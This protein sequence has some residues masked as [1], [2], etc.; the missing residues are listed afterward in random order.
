MEQR[1][2]RGAPNDERRTGKER[3]QKNKQQKENGQR[4]TA[5]KMPPKP[6]RAVWYMGRRG[7]SG[8]CAFDKGVRRFFGAAALHAGSGYDIIP[9]KGPSVGPGRGRMVWVHQVQ[10]QVK[11]PGRSA[12]LGL[13][14]GLFCRAAGLV[15]RFGPWAGLCRSGDSRARARKTL[16]FEKRFQ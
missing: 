11:C 16:S 6:R 1:S 10:G 14:G 15:G 2:K 3:K 13:S 12:A 7:R 8:L 9:S 4:M 5:K